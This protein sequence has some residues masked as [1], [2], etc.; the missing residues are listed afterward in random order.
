MYFTAPGNLLGM[1]HRILVGGVLPI[2]RDTVYYTAP[3]D[4]VTGNL[5]GITNPSADIQLL[6]STA[7][8]ELATG[9]SLEVS[10]PFAEMQSLTGPY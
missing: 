1:G 6:F 10:Y 3:A 9:H 5:S 4:W 7:P 8:S 2:C